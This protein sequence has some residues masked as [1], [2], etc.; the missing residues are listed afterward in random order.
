VAERQPGSAFKPI[1][2]L[3][4]LDPDR[5]P[6]S[7]PLTL[8]SILPDRPMSFNGWTP[9]NY[10]RTYR[11]EVTV[12]DALAESLNVPTAYVGSLLGAPAI[13]RTAH[14]LGINGELAP[15]LPIAIGADE[16]TLLELTSAY[17]VFADAGMAAPPYAI[18][19]VVDG[20]G[21]VILHH[22]PVAQHVVSARAA[23]LITGALEGVLAY[24][25]GAGAARMGLDFPAAGKTG[26]TEDYRD[27]YFIG[28]T[29]DLVCGVWVGFDR[30]QSLGLPGAQ[31][32][33]P[34][35]TNFMIQAASGSADDFERPAGITM[36]VVD[37][38]SGGLATTGCPRRIPLPFLSGTEPTHLCPLHRGAW[39]STAGA[40][41]P[42][43]GAGSPSAIPVE[44]RAAPP[45]VLGKLGAFVNR[46]FRR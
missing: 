4:A 36:A 22:E 17:Q 41:A 42:E 29:P 2:Y 46:V 39:T 14:E 35:W 1:V 20:K 38:A 7:P 28:Y 3:A 27:A 15:V 34:A 40:S 8:A 10:E 9:V 45:G 43:T 24:G 13:V 21:H 16:T 32:A 44:T 31:A 5:S 37:P 26:T 18:E 25:T 11:G 19:S 30:P 12:A 6:L 33:L 23:Y